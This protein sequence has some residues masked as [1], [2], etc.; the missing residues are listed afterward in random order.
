MR[1]KYRAGVRFGIVTDKRVDRLLGDRV[2]LITGEGTPRRYF[3][4]ETFIVDEINRVRGPQRNQALGS[5]GAAYKYPIRI[6]GYP[7]FQDLK[8][9]A[10]NFAYGLQPIKS[11]RI[12]RGLQEISSASA[13]GVN[14]AAPSKRGAGFG[15]AENNRRIER[16]AIRAVV[17]DYTMRGWRTDS[18]ERPWGTICAAPEARKRSTSR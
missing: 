15:I 17:Q 2:W 7:W 13:Q 1:G 12:I 6:D 18:R 8:R 14:V 3:L 4:C 5:E 16:A 10:G 9:A 11:Q